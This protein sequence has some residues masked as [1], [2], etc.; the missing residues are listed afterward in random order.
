MASSRKLLWLAV[1]ALVLFSTPARADPTA[2]QREL[3]RDLMQKGHD[4]RNA[5][6]PKVALESFKGADDIMHVPTTAFEVA[7]SQV[8]LGQLVEAHETLLGVM[9]APERAGEPQ[10]FHDTRGY[11][12]VLDDEVVARIPQLRIKVDGGTPGRTPTVVVDGVAL[13]EGALLVPYKVDPGHHVVTAKTDAADGRAEAEVAERETKD[14]TVTLAAVASSPGAAVPVP[15]GA[16]APEPAP[17]TPEAPQAGRG[18]GPVAWAGFGVAAAG[19]ALGTVTGI[20][21]LSDKG[22]IAS[23]CNGNHCPPSTYGAL[24]SANTLA[25]V[26]TVSFVVAGV[27]GGVGLVGWLLGRDPGAPPPATGIRITPFIGA[28]AAGATGT[29]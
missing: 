25:L 17:P 12:K 19:L 27:G 2:Q 6:D 7:R 9:R 15:T 28:G 8:D 26:S 13:P 21:T 22:S 4:A 29:F 11:A 20:M 14:V 1:L 3:A 16:P 18:P 23:Q 24:S 10:V 5:H